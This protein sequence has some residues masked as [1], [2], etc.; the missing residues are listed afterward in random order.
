[1]SKPVFISHAVANRELADRLVDLFET[2]VGI[3]DGDIFCSSLQGMGIPSGVNFADFIR[4]QI[5][6]PRVVVL[7]LS[8]EY[9]NSQFCVCELGLNPA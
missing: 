3:P 5:R 4:G 1:M 7:V 6:D 2:G 9:F 8:Q